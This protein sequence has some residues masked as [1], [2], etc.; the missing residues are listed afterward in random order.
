MI[1]G[2]ALLEMMYDNNSN[3]IDCRYL[4]A[5][6]A[7]EKLTE[8]KSEDII[9]KTARECIEGLEDIW[10]K[11]YEQVDKTGEPMQIENYIA[12]LKS[13]YK[14]LA[15]RPTQGLVAVVFEN[16]TERKQ[17]EDKS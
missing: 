4:D 10:I 14:V 1:N 5:N 8:L 3:V 15:Y 17:A 6:P 9:G 2:F 16:I 13:W 7:H 12:G 11:N